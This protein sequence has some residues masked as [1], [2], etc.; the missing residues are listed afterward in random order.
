MSL[1]TLT[2]N[3]MEDGEPLVKL[4]NSEKDKRKTGLKATNL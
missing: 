3:D 1:K 2:F 4:R